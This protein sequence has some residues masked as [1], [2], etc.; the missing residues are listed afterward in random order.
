MRR[1]ELT[2]KEYIYGDERKANNI[3]G[4]KQEAEV[5]DAV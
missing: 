2:D 5:L 1:E 4:G 3:L